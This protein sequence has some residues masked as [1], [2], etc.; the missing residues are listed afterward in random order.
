MDLLD[1]QLAEG[2]KGNFERG[3]EIAQQLEKE[4]PWCNRSAFN[5]GWYEM[6]RGDLYKGFELMNR[7]R[8]EEV[9]GNLH[10][11]TNK[12]IY[13][14]KPLNGEHVLFTCEAGFGDQMVFL[15]F[16]EGIHK[17]G[18]KVTVGCSDSLMSLFSRYEYASSVVNYKASL[19]VYHDYWV[20]SMS[21]P[22]I[23][24]TTY[25][26]L[27]GK[28]YLRADEKFIRKH[29][30]LSQ[31]NK[32]KV[33]IRWQGL[34]DF[35]HEQYRRFPKELMF[36]AVKDLDN[37]Q[38]FSLQ[39]DW[40]EELPNY[41]LPTHEYLDTWEDTAGLIENMDLVISSCTSVAHLAGA[42]GKPTWVIVP[43]L[44]YYIWA[45][46]GNKSPWYDSITVYRQERFGEWEEPFI[47]IKNQLL[48]MNNAIQ[49]FR[50]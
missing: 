25:D 19:G 36:N 20:P 44:P 6:M 42:M 29:K 30:I 28:P 33:G 4:R 14:G 11:G 2:L 15:R 38:I 34:P 31:E 49:N 26:D 12:P 32:L 10:I 1:E 50:N 35:E 5:R 41:I 46:P 24:K 40:D 22:V 47:E 8:W 7:G 16:V 27:S 45:L 43:I 37:T 3:W 21:A 9:W 23:L 48:E 39:K 13:D 18:G 17:A